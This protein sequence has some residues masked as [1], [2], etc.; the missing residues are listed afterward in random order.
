MA[1]VYVLPYGEVILVGG[2]ILAVG[3]N[4][5]FVVAENLEGDFYFEKRAIRLAR[6][7]NSA[8]CGP[9]SQSEFDKIAAGL[10]L[11]EMRRLGKRK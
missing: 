9:Y 8:V 3:S 2:P 11:P 5:Q 7:P 10:K 6:S 4:D 1:I